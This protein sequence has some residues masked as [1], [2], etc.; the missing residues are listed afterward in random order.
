MVPP[1]KKAV[2]RAVIPTTLDRRLSGPWRAVRHPDESH[3]GRPVLTTS[4]E[5][6]CMLATLDTLRRDFGGDIIRPGDASYPA[7]SGSILA[8]GAPA[9]VLRPGGVEDVRAAVRFAAGSGLALAV[10]GG[11]HGFPGFGTNDGGVVIDLR[12]LSDVEVL[13]PDRHL[14]RVGGGAT[15]GEVAVALAPYGLAIS[16]GD[17]KGVG[18]GGLTLTGGIGW[19]VRRYGL[20]LDNVVGA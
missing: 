13:D 9:L 20:A 1:R 10:R 6:T 3:T 12:R 11:G 16:S 17:T 14:V 7:A 2:M 4:S 8:S 19:K 15:W 5:G 18:V